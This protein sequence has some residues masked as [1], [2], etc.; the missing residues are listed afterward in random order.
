MMQGVMDGACSTY[1]EI[2]NA[3]NILIGKLEGTRHLG[4]LDV[5]WSIVLKWRL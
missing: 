1:G 5:D 4:R 3:Y 2:R